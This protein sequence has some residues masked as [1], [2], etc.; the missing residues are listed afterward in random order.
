MV[1]LRTVNPSKSWGGVVYDSKGR[2]RLFVKGATRREVVDHEL[3]YCQDNLEPKQ[4]R[5]D[6]ILETTMVGYYTGITGADWKD[7]QGDHSSSSTARRSDIKAA[8]DDAVSTC[9]KAAPR[10][11]CKLL[12]A[13]CADGSSQTASRSASRGGQVRSGQSVAA[14]P[15]SAKPQTLRRT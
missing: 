5:L 9:A 3:S 14:A 1:C 12:A 6:L 2:Y 4:C 13:V 7:G 11:N 10:D 8:S 15:G